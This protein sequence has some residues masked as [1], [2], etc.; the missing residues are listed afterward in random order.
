MKNSLSTLIIV[1]NLQICFLGLTS[2]EGLNPV[3][4]AIVNAKPVLGYDGVDFESEKQ[5]ELSFRVTSLGF[6]EN[7]A[8][9]LN[10]ML[11]V[12]VGSG[13][14]TLFFYLAQLKK[15]SMKNAFKILQRETMLIVFFT[16]TNTFFSLSIFMEI[17]VMN[18]VFACVAGAIVLFQVAHFLVYAKEYF[19]M[20][21]TIGNVNFFRAFIAVFVVSRLTSCVILG[22]VQDEPEMAVVGVIASEG[23]LIMI[24]CVLRPFLHLICNLLVIFGE[25]LSCFFF[26]S[27]YTMEG[28]KE[29]EWTCGWMMIGALC[30]I[31][32]A[33]VANLGYSIYK[34][35]TSS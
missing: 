7:F 4:Q 5:E 23:I 29:N 26:V 11:F 1:S 8:N 12:C 28:M 9:N 16:T 18:L 6:E 24:L 33:G 34:D 21:N 3:N 35:C 31:G 30:G 17:T 19:G 20:E 14:F 13:M 25:M 10:I 15:P 32:V 2:I 22:T 27:I